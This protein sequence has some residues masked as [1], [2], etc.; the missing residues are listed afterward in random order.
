MVRW[1]NAHLTISLP[2]DE[3]Q[4][5]KRHTEIKWGAVARKLVLQYLDD[6]EKAQELLLKSKQIPESNRP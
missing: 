4:R 5:I 3:Y 1:L 2:E 6:I